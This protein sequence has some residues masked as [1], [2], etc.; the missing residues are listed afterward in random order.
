MIHLL[1]FLT[2]LKNAT[3]TLVFQLGVTDANIA[4]TIAIYRPF[5]SI[6]QKPDIAYE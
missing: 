6:L 3:C 5:V 4:H 2:N 1:V